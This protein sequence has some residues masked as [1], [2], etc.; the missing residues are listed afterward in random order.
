MLKRTLVLP[1]LA[2]ALLAATAADASADTLVAAAPGARN[3]TA[4]GGYVVWAAPAAPPD[5]GA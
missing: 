5:A 3:L 2:A 1:L 4:N